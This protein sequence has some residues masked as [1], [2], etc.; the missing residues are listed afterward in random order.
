MYDVSIP[1]IWCNKSGII[2]QSKTDSVEFAG[3]WMAG[4][5]DGRDYIP[6]EYWDE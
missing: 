4:L 1:I 5:M 3:S 6:D 2:M